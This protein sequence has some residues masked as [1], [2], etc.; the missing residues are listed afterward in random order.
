MDAAALSKAIAAGGGK[1][2]LKIVSGGTLTATSLDGKV[3]VMDES[4]ATAN[5]TNAD[6]IQSNGVIH[7]VYK[8]LLPK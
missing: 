7:V 8:V 5:V 3:M 2:T 4:G 1:A 6:V